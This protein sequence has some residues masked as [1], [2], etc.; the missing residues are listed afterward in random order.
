MP[1]KGLANNARTWDVTLPT[2][3]TIS[4]HNLKQWCAQQGI[5]AKYLG[6][7]AQGKRAHHK[8]ITLKLAEVQPAP[9]RPKRTGPPRPPGPSYQPKTFERQTERP[10]D[11]LENAQAPNRGLYEI[12][13]PDGSVHENVSGLHRFC[14]AH[15]LNPDT[16]SQ[17][18][19]GLRTKSYYGWTAK[20]IKAP[21]GVK[22]QQVRELPPSNE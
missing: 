16:M 18:A 15:G 22:N 9:K 5:N 19:R 8:G 11:W 12:T 20:Q 3:E 21:P 17:I 2:G 1:R 7:V 14:R 13:E 6:K 4:V 10:D